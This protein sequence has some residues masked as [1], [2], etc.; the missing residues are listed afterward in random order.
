M[1]VPTRNR[2]GGSDLDSLIFI[3]FGL[4]G[5]GLAF[6]LYMLLSGKPEQDD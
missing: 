2:T 4:I 3:G 5:F 6:F 1:A